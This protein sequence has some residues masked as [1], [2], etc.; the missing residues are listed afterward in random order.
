MVGVADWRLVTF[1]PSAD[2]GSCFGLAWSFFAHCAPV[3]PTVKREG[4]NTHSRTSGRGGNCSWSPGGPSWVQY[5]NLSDF[6]RRHRWG[7][8]GSEWRRSRPRTSANSSGYFIPS[9]D[10]GPLLGGTHSPGGR[11][12]AG[13]RRPIRCCWLPSGTVHTAYHGTNE[14]PRCNISSGPKRVEAV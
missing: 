2:F 8:A 11:S 5:A 9:G 1:L 13:N 6:S 14:C 7:I 3:C 4:W 10:V 12:R